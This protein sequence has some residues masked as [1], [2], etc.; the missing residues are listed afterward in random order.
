VGVE[1][2]EGKERGRLGRVGTV[3]TKLARSQRLKS[4]ARCPRVIFLPLLQS[5]SYLN[6]SACHMCWF[7]KK[8]QGGMGSGRAS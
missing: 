1:G 6:L 3:R 5:F 4:L 8:S 2:L 7:G